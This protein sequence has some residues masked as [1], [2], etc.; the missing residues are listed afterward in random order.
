MQ[1][2]PIVQSGWQFSK[3]EGAGHHL[4]RGSFI[5]YKLSAV[6][7]LSVW[8]QK[9]VAGSKARKGAS[10][11]HHDRAR[12]SSQNRH[13]YCALNIF[14]TDLSRKLIKKLAYQEAYHISMIGNFGVF[15]R[16]SFLLIWKLTFFCH[17]LCK[18][19]TLLF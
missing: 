1:T 18:S 4:N 12:N 2:L 19:P 14:N 3:N 15:S 11:L 6:P 17:H 16:F 10:L 5:F 7:H 8:P 13:W 9:Y